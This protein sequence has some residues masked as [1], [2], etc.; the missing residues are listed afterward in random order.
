MTRF[1]D[2][3]AQIDALLRTRL[4]DRADA[5]DERASM[6][7]LLEIVKRMANGER[8]PAERD[9]VDRAL[10][11]MASRAGESWTVAILARAAGL[12]R[13][14][15]AR[16][17]HKRFGMSPMR[18]LADLRMREAA[19]LL[20]ETDATLALI[21]AEVGYESEFAFSR[22]FKR[23]SGEAPGT[24]R[25]KQRTSRTTVARAA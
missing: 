17:F 6:Q 7:T 9:P 13:A 1:R 21:A 19:R 4:A 3:L 15:F 5:D 8:T 10:A 14:A 12:S 11:L 22:A 18:Y 24:Y 2:V 25:R 16:Q 23:H 20:S